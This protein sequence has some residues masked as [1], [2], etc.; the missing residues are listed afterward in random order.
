[1]VT[2]A[3]L[4]SFWRERVTRIGETAKGVLGVRSKVQRT[5]TI[6]RARVF[7]AGPAGPRAKDRNS[8]EPITSHL[9]PGVTVTG[10]LDTTGVIHID[11]RLIG[12]LTADRL[13]V[14][15]E[16]YVEGDIVANDARLGG[17]VKGNVYARNVTVGHTAKITGRIFHNAATV[18]KG[19]HIDG[20]MPWRPPAYFEKLDHLR[21]AQ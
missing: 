8:L 6:E 5:A 2:K 15:R 13:A 7:K 4:A 19:A 18:A 14:G 21:E 9:G 16:G 3:E 12:H 10:R 11:G 17:R 1:M 20:R